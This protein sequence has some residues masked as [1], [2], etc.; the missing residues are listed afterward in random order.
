MCVL[1]EPFS[2]NVTVASVIVVNLQAGFFY[3]YTILKT[4]W[5][6]LI[7]CPQLC[8]LLLYQISGGESLDMAFDV[9]GE[10]LHVTSFISMSAPAS[11][12]VCCLQ[13]KV[14]CF[15]C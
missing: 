7:N 15:L 6:Q 9:R 2:I 8:N 1:T 14:I 12:L 13:T 4:A 5:F 11:N 3:Y 10:E